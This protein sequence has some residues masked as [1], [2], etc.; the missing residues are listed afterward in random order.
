MEKDDKIAIFST[1]EIQRHWYPSM[2]LPVRSEIVRKDGR[3]AKFASTGYLEKAIKEG[4]E[5]YVASTRSSLH[6]HD[7]WWTE[8]VKSENI[9]LAREDKDNLVSENSS[10]V[11][12]Y[13]KLDLPYPRRGKGDDDEKP[14]KG[15]YLHWSCARDDLK[16]K[17]GMTLGSYFAPPAIE[18]LRRMKRKRSK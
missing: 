6:E 10:W 11:Q 15:T 17:H 1:S 5:V 14:R 16:M 8:L 18:I 2:R 12:L 13:H 4:Y 3:I 9:F 7:K